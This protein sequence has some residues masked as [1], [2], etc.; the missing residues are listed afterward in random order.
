MLH[1][2]T[3]KEKQ[4]KIEFILFQIS[5]DESSPELPF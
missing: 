4:D 2:L 5:I 3:P 1:I